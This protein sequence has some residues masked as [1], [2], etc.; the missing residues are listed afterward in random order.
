MNKLL[1]IFQRTTSKVLALEKPARH[2]GINVVVNSSLKTQCQIIKSSLIPSPI[3]LREDYLSN[4]RMNISLTEGV[5]A[6]LTWLTIAA[7]NIHLVSFIWGEL[8]VIHRNI[9]LQKN[10]MKTKSYLR[11]KTCIKY[12]EEWRHRQHEANLQTKSRPT[13]IVL[14]LM[15]QKA[16]MPG[17]GP[18][19]K[20]DIVWRNQKV[21]YHIAGSSLPLHKRV[22][23][24]LLIIGLMAKCINE[25]YKAVFLT[26]RQEF[27]A[28]GN[29]L[30]CYKTPDVLVNLSVAFG[31]HELTFIVAVSA[32]WCRGACERCLLYNPQRG[33]LQIS[34]SNLSKIELP[35][36]INTVRECENHGTNMESFVRFKFYQT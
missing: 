23:A 12:T 25:N 10:K 29:R 7:D 13:E 1:A 5:F 11:I 14:A 18:K 4:M 3:T 2:K 34:R 36:G 9:E 32:M 31:V 8:K 19:I 28:D 24:L 6:L 30:R 27:D 15:L 20:A 35:R 21:S 26:K 16:N 22:P 33:A 17:A